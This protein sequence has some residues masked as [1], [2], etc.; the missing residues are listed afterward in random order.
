VD[1]FNAHLAERWGALVS[2]CEDIVVCPDD[3]QRAPEAARGPVQTSYIAVDDDF[4]AAAVR[5]A[6]EL[7]NRCTFL[8]LAA[9]TGE[10][11]RVAP[12]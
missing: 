7:R 5:H 4:H 8:D 9:D 3:L 10:F 1:R 2:D 11:D 6:R 12:A